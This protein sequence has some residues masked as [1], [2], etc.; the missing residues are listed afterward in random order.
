MIFNSTIFKKS[1]FSSALMLV[2]LL[3]LNSCK[4]NEV[5]NTVYS[6]I[7][8][9]NASP[10]SATYDAYLNGNK[11]N[12]AALPLGGG[13]AYVQQPAG[14]YELK[15][16]VSG[17]SESLLTK[18]IALI[19]NNYH[20]FFLI[21]RP[22]AFDGLLTSDEQIAPSTE[23]SFVRFVNVSPDAPALDAAVKN[24]ETIATNKAYKTYSKYASVAAGTYTFEVKGTT[25]GT[26]TATT[27]SITLK[28]NTYYTII[29]KGL[30]AP[31]GSL[32]QAFSAS[33]LKDK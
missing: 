10:T 12:G 22:N 31:T 14:S 18:T 7:S 11:M 13:L 16:T 24:G 6:A 29:A 8:V 5:D 4:E 15:F 27:E 21:G 3:M 25:P 20:T 30:V 28:A 2:G 9:I 32:E 17:R 19:D 26:V 23:A 33:V 1:F